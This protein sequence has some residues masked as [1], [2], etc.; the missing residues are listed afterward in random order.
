MKI[1]SKVVK[2]C[3]TETGKT[4]V[5]ELGYSYKK[6]KWK[7]LIRDYND[8]YYEYILKQL[9]KEVKEVYDKYKASK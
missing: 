8:E 9:R 1:L 7:V 2:E 3:D 4:I 6:K 5:L